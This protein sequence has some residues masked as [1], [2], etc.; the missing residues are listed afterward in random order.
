MVGCLR[1]L[2][3]LQ[4]FEVYRDAPEAF[5]YTIYA[6]FKLAIC[7]VY[8]I[9]VI[10]KYCLCKRYCYCTLCASCKK[11]FGFLGFCMTVLTALVSAVFGAP[12][13]VVERSAEEYKRNNGLSN[14]DGDN[15]ANKENNSDKMVACC[16]TVCIH[17]QEVEMEDGNHVCV[18]AKQEEDDKQLNRGVKSL[19]IH[20]IELHTNELLMLSVVA[21]P[22]IITIAT[23]FWD[24]FLLKQTISCTEDPDVY[25]FPLAIPPTTNSD[26]NITSGTT[27]ITD[28]SKWMTSDISM[29]VTFRCFECVNNLEDAFAALGGLITIF[30]LAI[31]LGITALIQF[32]QCI[33]KMLMCCCIDT[34][35]SAIN[36]FKYTR[37][38]LGLILA[39]VEIVLAFVLGISYAQHRLSHGSLIDHE[40]TIYIVFDHIN[41]PLVLFGIVTTSLLLPLE[42]YI[43]VGE[44]KGYSKV[45]GKDI[46]G[47]INPN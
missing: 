32:T 46:Q 19:Y 38:T 26:L 23:T 11:G 10:N 27:R 41:E 25:C 22:F 12:L 47:N 36:K 35:E 15:E 42:E 28:C 9:V 13:G 29:N 20:G 5:A 39:A 3:T 7:I 45:K 6:F 1:N 14:A 21:V 44:R 4:D 16:L 18:C 17:P 31:K 37:I 30:K 40:S 24:R 8:F 43:D 33:V 34:S 2:R